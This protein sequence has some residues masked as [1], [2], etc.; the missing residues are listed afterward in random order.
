[1]TIYIDLIFSVLN[2]SIP[3]AVK[4][5]LIVANDTLY[6]QYLTGTMYV[7]PDRC[8]DYLLIYRPLFNDMIS[9]Y[10]GLKRPLY[11]VLQLQ[12]SLRN[13]NQN[14]SDTV[15]VSPEYPQLVIE[16]PQR[17]QGQFFTEEQLNYI[18]QHPN[19]T[20]EAIYNEFLRSKK[21]GLKLTAEQKSLRAREVRA[22][23]FYQAIQEVRAE[24][25]IPQK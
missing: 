5:V 10:A 1:M 2:L 7:L 13:V 4:D 17:S 15:S 3:P 22:M 19:N 8:N 24:G 9:Y 23:H 20:E 11:H 12:S 18:R 6:N 25:P 16:N 21:E 14:P